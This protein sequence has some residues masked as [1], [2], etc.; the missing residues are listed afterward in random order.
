MIIHKILNEIFTTY[1]HIAIIRELR[2]SKN[3]FTGREIA[4]NAGI[5]PPSC[6]EALSKLENLKI[7]N[8][9]IGGNVYIFTLNFDNYLVK[10]GILPL[11]EIEQSIP[12]KVSL[13]LKKAL[14]KYST[15]V[16]LFGSVARHEETHSSDYDICIVYQKQSN[17]KKIEDIIN[18]IR[19][20][21]YTQFGISLAPYYTSISEFKQRAKKKLS[22]VNNIVK[23]GNVLFGKSIR[24]LLN[25]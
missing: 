21:F 13:H 2:F 20:N 8:R 7:V 16:I 12:H 14:S 9:Q 10:E 1:S 19:H 23:E 15:S 25:D 18:Q 11:L 3:G 17:K 4:K 5:S 22:P 6:L 24:E